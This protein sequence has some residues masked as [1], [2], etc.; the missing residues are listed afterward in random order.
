MRISNIWSRTAV[1]YQCIFPSHT[2]ITFND[3][4]LPNEIVKKMFD[5]VKFHILRS[6]VEIYEISGHAF[7]KNPEG[8]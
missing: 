4:V 3:Y 6:I 2:S 1:K 5:I 7:F 8:L